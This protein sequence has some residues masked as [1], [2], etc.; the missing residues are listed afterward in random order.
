MRVVAFEAGGMAGV[1][2]WNSDESAIRPFD[3]TPE[4]AAAGVLALVDRDLDGRPAQLTDRRLAADQVTLL[5]AAPRPRRNIFCVGKNYHAHAEEF[6]A[7]GF[8]SS[9]KAGAVPAHPIVFSKVPETVIPDGAPILI[10]T[11]VSE[12]IDYEVELAVIVGRAGRG[13]AKEDALGHVWGYTLLN[14]VTARD[15]QQRHSQWLLGK[16]QDS[17]CPMSALAV[18]ADE[19]DLADTQLRCWINEDLRQDA[20]TAQLI[21]D[22]PTLISTISAGI[23]LLPGDIIATGTPEGVGIGFDPPRYLKAGDR[24]RMEISGIGSL[25]NPVEQV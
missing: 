7:S 24:V 22:V 4:E 10:D 8:D 23:T 21:F 18:T 9:A 6:A 1:G 2:L 17:F 25:A 5:A 11:S 15:L 3:L 20:N 14:D 13:I 12:A 16:S 19:I